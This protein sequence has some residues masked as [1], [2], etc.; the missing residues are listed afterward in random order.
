LKT[1]IHFNNLDNKILQRARKQL[2][3]Y[4]TWLVYIDNFTFS[5]TSNEISLNEESRE[6]FAFPQLHNL[7]EMSSSQ[8]NHNDVVT[9]VYKQIFSRSI[10]NLPFTQLE[11]ERCE[12]QDKSCLNKRRGD[13][14]F[15]S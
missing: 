11:H 10:T 3:H 8:N 13:V 7:Q 5:R 1:N 2:Q 6:M 14:S 15:S 4:E 9:Q 12:T